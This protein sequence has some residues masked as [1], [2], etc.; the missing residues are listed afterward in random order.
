MVGIVLGAA[1]FFVVFWVDA[2]SVHNVRHVKPLL[3]ISAAALFMAGLVLAARDPSPFV[4]PAALSAAGWVLATLFFLLL[5]YSLFI[6]IPLVSAY[7]RKGTAPAVVCRGTYALCRHPGVLWLA[8]FL[9]SL[10]L[11]TGSRALIIAV[12][13]W[14]GLDVL[15]VVLQER[16]YFVRM[17]GAAYESYQRTV[18]LLVPN[19][20][21]VRECIR[22]VFR[23]ERM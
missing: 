20:R 22:T 9:L 11:A 12:P 1:S 14:V 5:V 3:W 4:L 2:V 8:G 13:L 6:E 18:P 21:S 23:T 17:F 16:L 7:V 15:W 10:L 19:P